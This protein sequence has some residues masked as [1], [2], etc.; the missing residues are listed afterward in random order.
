M[1]ENSNAMIIGSKIQI[2]ITNDY[3]N[4]EKRD[5]NAK[6]KVTKYSKKDKKDITTEFILEE[7]KYMEICNKILE[8]NPKNL[9]HNNSNEL[10]IDG[11]STELKFGTENEGISYG[12]YGLEGKTGNAKYKDLKDIVILIFNYANEKRRGFN[13]D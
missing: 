7:K 2:E 13:Y 12:V 8:L 1:L 11:Y 6:I 10:Q 5:N 3:L 4:P 9:L